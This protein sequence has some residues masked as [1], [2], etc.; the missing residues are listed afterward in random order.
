MK[1]NW[2]DGFWKILLKVTDDEFPL[3]KVFPSAGLEAT[4]LIPPVDKF[5][6][7][8]EPKVIPEEISIASIKAWAGILLVNED[9]ALTYRS[10]VRVI[11]PP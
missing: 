2:F 7:K 9:N 11:L 3:V 6:I 10:A 5:S 4:M 1:F 8:K